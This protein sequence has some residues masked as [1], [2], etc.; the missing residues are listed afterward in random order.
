MDLRQVLPPADR[1]SDPRRPLARAARRRKRRFATAC[2]VPSTI[3]V[4]NLLC[5]H[6][7]QPG[8]L[9]F[10]GMHSRSHR[11]GKIPDGV[12]HLAQDYLYELKTISAASSRHGHSSGDIAVD[13]R[14]GKIN[15]GYMDTAHAIDVKWNAT[16]AG[17]QGPFETAL[18]Q[19]GD[20]GDHCIQGLCVGMFDGISSGTT[21]LLR[22]LAQHGAE[23]L[24]QRMGSSS[25]KHWRPC[26]GLLAGTSALSFGQPTPTSSSTASSTWAARLRAIVPANVTL[27]TGSSARRATPQ[28][29]LGL[30]AT[31]RGRWRPTTRTS[32]SKMTG[33]EKPLDCKRR[34]GS[35]VTPTLFVGVLPSPDS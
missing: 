10:S 30:T 22:I 26:F 6:I 14:A 12:F 34:P 3:E 33:T 23:R 7:S 5:Q 24:I 25:M 1:H 13:K 31:Q 21:S 15:A 11:Q 2:Q 9:H 16:I 17:Q 28:P 32:E 4:Y 29:P 18:R 35:T 20:G 27:S 8:R 19:Y